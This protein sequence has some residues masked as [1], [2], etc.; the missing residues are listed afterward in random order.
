MN[1]YLFMQPLLIERIK[2]AVT[3]LAQV[4]SLHNLEAIDTQS[5]ASPACWIIYCGDAANDDKAGK[6]QVTQYWAAVLS[7]YY[8]DQLQIG[9]LLGQLINALSDWQPD[10]TQHAGISPLQR[11]NEN[12]PVSLEGELLIFPLLFKAGFIWPRT[13]PY[14]AP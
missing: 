3:G 10:T 5:A 14:G 4:D 12:L 7:V 2:S 8:K 9:E 11:A 6:N 13:K 1:N